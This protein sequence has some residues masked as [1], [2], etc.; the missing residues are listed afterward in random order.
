MQPVLF[1]YWG[2]GHVYSKTE[3]FTATITDDTDKH[4]PS[5]PK[6][7]QHIPSSKANSQNKPHILWKPKFNSSYI[8][9]LMNNLTDNTNKCTSI[10]MYTVTYNPLKLQHVLI[11][12]RSSSGSLHQTTTYT[13][14]INY[15]I[16]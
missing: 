3:M 10:K 6:S 5:L 4:Q 15:H 9:A 1:N 14:Q 13:T 8:H 12:L 2:G 7:M 16:E 11:F